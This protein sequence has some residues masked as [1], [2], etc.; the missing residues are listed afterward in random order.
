MW[1]VVT[2]GFISLAAIS[3]TSLANRHT[4]RIPSCSSLLRILILFRTPNF[5]TA[6]QQG[7]HSRPAE[8]L[9]YLFADWDAGLGVVW[10][11]YA[12]GNRASRTQRVYWA[13]R[14][15]EGKGGE[16]IEVSICIGFRDDFR[17]KDGGEHT[18][19]CFMGLLVRTLCTSPVN[20]GSGSVPALSLNRP[21]Q[22]LLKQS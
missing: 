11:L 22:F 2:P 18:V 3:S 20:T 7:S 13:Q 12:L 16:G 21:T 19:G 15:G 8:H 14:S 6:R 17:R 10:Q 5:W 9:S 4:F 1:S